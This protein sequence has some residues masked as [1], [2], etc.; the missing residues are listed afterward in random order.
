MSENTPPPH[1]TG[2]TQPIEDDAIQAFYYSSYLD[3]PYVQALQSFLTSNGIN[4]N[5]FS[6]L[7]SVKVALVRTLGHFYVEG[8]KAWVDNPSHSEDSEVFS[9]V[10]EALFENAELQDRLPGFRGPLLSEVL[11]NPLYLQTINLITGK[12]DQIVLKQ[13]KDIFRQGYKAGEALAS[14]CVAGELDQDRAQG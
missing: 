14:R 12:I 8:V 6:F 2:L 4:K 10:F 13:K 1:T 11:G 7:H 9:E 5:N 3:V